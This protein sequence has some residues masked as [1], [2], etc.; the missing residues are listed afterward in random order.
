MIKAM[1][2]GKEFRRI[3]VDTGSSVD[4]LFKSALN[5][6]GIADLKLERMNTSLKGFEG[7]G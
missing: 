2:A 7:G 3:L 5:D 4:I 6:M 1:V